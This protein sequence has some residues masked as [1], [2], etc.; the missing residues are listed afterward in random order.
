MILATKSLLWLP[1]TILFLGQLSCVRTLETMPKTEVY[2]RMETN[3]ECSEGLSL[4]VEYG[5][6]ELVD[7][8]NNIHQV[9]FDRAKGGKTYFL[10]IIVRDHSAERN[11]MVAFRCGNTVIKEANYEEI[12]QLATGHVEDREYFIVGLGGN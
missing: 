7:S 10:G 2:L 8:I 3:S 6:S 4:D 5:T 1:I 12:S 9:T 11:N